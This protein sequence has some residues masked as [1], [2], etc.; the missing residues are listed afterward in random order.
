[1]ATRKYLYPEG[2]DTPEQR[3]R[4]RRQ[5]RKL[6]SRGREGQ[7]TR[8]QEARAY[9]PE[10]FGEAL[11]QVV[12]SFTR[13]FEIATS[14]IR[15]GYHP[16]TKISVR[17]IETGRRYNL[18]M[19]LTGLRLIYTQ[20][21]RE[22]TTVWPIWMQRGFL[23]QPGTDRFPAGG[24]SLILLMLH[25]LAHVLNGLRGTWVRGETHGWGF[26]KALDD[27]IS[28]ANGKGWFGEDIE[29]R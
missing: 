22:Y 16:G 13:D 8:E 7:P 25:E 15:L 10:R 19:G 4:Y 9:L 3:K 17:S 1:M 11:E 23:P 28:W 14:A 2:C 6:A 29:K 21:M 24:R 5:Q 12:N 27:L 18:N 20:G 26:Q